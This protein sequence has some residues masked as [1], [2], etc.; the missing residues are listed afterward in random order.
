MTTGA[1]H[2]L[3]RGGAR[4]LTCRFEVP[5]RLPAFV[6]LPHAE[7]P[8][9][10]AAVDRVLAFATEPCGECA[11]SKERSTGEPCRACQ[12]SGAG[13]RPLF[14]RSYDQAYGPRRW[15]IEL[16]PWQKVAGG[17]T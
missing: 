2:F 9:S 4:A 10:L 8:A 12:G 11:G 16:W 15:R 13:L 6:E 7:A 17:V 5:A 3:M 14:V 1:I